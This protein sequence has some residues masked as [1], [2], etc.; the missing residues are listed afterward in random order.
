MIRLDP[1]SS[2][3]SEIDSPVNYFATLPEELIQKIFSSLREKD[4]ESCSKVSKF[5][6]MSVI[7]FSCDRLSKFT[8]IL[9]KRLKRDGFYKESDS[10][11]KLL[12]AQLSQKKILTN[13]SLIKPYTSEIKE[14]IISIIQKLEGKNLDNLKTY[15]ETPLYMKDIFELSKVHNAARIPDISEKAKALKNIVKNLL[16]LGNVSEAINV[17]RLIP[18]NHAARKD[19]IHKISNLLKERSESLIKDGKI[20]QAVQTAML[21][22][23]EMGQRERVLTDISE[24]LR[25]T[26]N[27][28]KSINVAFSIRHIPK[29]ES[30]LKE[31]FQHLRKGGCI[32][33]AFELLEL[34]P[35]S[36]KEEAVEQAINDI[37]EAVNRDRN[38]EQIILQNLD[39][40][41]LESIRNGVLRLVNSVSS[42]TSDTWGRSMHLSHIC[43][44]LQEIGSIDSA[45]EVAKLI[46]HTA[47]RRSSFENIL[48]AIKEV[49]DIN[50]LIEVANLIPEGSQKKDSFIKELSKSF[51]KIGQTHRG[52]QIALL[53]HRSN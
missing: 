27:I 12:E 19:L 2:K 14:K 49:G 23:H 20:D 39:K 18:R 3:N 48:E 46:P 30:L 31:I 43:E 41:T 21:I 33:K 22:P 45:I 6:N 5:L 28:D 34:I 1:L 29:R 32:D 50:K 7:N 52:N 24:A 40:R 42:D 53:M 15:V 51:S 17:T 25:K 13:F 37:S 44:A 16:K 38:K 8:H 9:S 11:E 10:L 47:L 36:G 26:G 35:A 4:L